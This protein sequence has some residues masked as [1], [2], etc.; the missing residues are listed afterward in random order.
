M[1]HGLADASF[2]PTAKELST[3]LQWFRDHPVLAAAAATAVS[4]IT[5]LNTTETLVR[6]ASSSASQLADD[7]D[8]EC[9]GMGRADTAFADGDDDYDTGNAGGSGG[10]SSSN[11]YGG[12]SVLYR[13]RVVTTTTRSA[14]ERGAKTPPPGVA[15]RS[16]SDGKLSA[17]VSW[18]DEHGGSLTQVFE[19][20][21][22]TE[23]ERISELER[24]SEMSEIQDAALSCSGGEENTGSFR[25]ESFASSARV[26]GA[27]A[28][29]LPPV[30]TLKKSS[31]QQSILSG[32]DAPVGSTHGRTSSCHHDTVVSTRLEAPTEHD[33]L[34]TESPQ[35]GWYVA[36]TPPQDHLHP[37]VPRAAMQPY[38]APYAA[39]NGASKI[40]GGI[41]S[42]RRS[43]SGQIP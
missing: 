2:F 16:A 18:C 8:D 37:N 31:T 9:R 42:L 22:L 24:S 20:W 3:G 14:F 4:V 36:I 1:S 5:Y 39:T 30:G 43:T 28:A 10:G 34:Q 38:R 35:W 32:M 19:E 33:S 21:H 27:A 12:R 23:E 7:D 15:H 17:A 26:N 6:S 41:S 29:R 25:D 13:K 11:M 40:Y